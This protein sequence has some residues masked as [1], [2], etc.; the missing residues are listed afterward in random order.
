MALDYYDILGI[1]PKAEAGEIKK[2]YR[3]L[4][5]KW[6]PDRNPGDFKAKERFLQLGEAYRVLSD[7]ARRAAYDWLRFQELTG[8]TPDPTSYGESLQGAGAV[9][10]SRV[11]RPRARPRSPQRQTSGGK[12]GSR[13]GRMATSRSCPPKPAFPQWSKVLFPWWSS[14][15]GWPQRF[16][17]WLTGYPPPDLEWHF[18]SE[19]NQPDLVMELRLPKRLA[20]RGTRLNLVIK[21]KNLRR[22]L[23]V[24]IPAGVR[25][26]SCLR[27]KGAG[28]AA[29]PRRGHLYIN[30]RLKD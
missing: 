20:N 14:L 28:K 22:R 30:I 29:L 25:D 15:K 17:N 16:L 18:V 4:A 21:G 6:H 10:F 5:L 12:D 9:H 19:G 13:K 1:S 7:P 26:G 8:G 2:A 11:G 24:L 3:L 23:K 27:I